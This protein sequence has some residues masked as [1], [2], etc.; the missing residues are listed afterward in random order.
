MDT[1]RSRVC[2]VLFH[3]L[4]FF[5]LRIMGD[6]SAQTEQ[7]C[8]H[9]RFDLLVK[10]TIAAHGGREVDFEEPGF[11]LVVN[12]DVKAEE[13][14]AVVFVRAKHFDCVVYDVLT[15]YDR[16]QNYVLY[17]FPNRFIIL[18]IELH[19]LSQGGN[20]PLRPLAVI[21]RIL[22]LLE[23]GIVLVQGVVR[24]MHILL[25]FQ[26]SFA[27]DI[28]LSGKSGQPIFID[29]DA[30][31]INAGERDID[32]QVEL[33]AVNKHRV[34]HVLGDD[35]LLSRRNVVDIFRDEDAFA[36]AR[37][38][39]LDDPGLRRIFD[40]L[41][42]QSSHLVWQDESQRQKLEVPVAVNFF[43]ACQ[44]PVHAVFAANLRTLR[45][46]IH[47]LVAAERLVKL[48]LDV[49]ASP[50]ELPL[51][52]AIVDLSEAIVFTGVPDQGHIDPVVEFEVIALI[53][54][55]VRPDRYGVNVG[56]KDQ[57][58]LVRL[59]TALNSLRGT[60]SF[61]KRH[62]KFA[63]LVLYL[64]LLNLTLDHVCLICSFDLGMSC[65]NARDGGLRL[66]WRESYVEQG[67]LLSSASSNFTSV[68]NILPAITVVPDGLL[69]VLFESIVPLDEL[70][71][72]P[73]H[74]F[75][76]LHH[77]LDVYLPHVACFVVRSGENGCVRS[78]HVRGARWIRITLGFVIHAL[79]RWVCRCLRLVIRVE[80]ADDIIQFVMVSSAAD[81]DV[82]V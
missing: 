75:E 78:Y 14:E 50:A 79:D 15:R 29:V 16:L 7:I 55:L 72:F 58:L 9:I 2:H 38:T 27:D 6:N 69:L 26:A 73:F 20:R 17:L 52:V 82:P 54:R 36:L 76:L 35:H 40:H 10:R 43:Q 66:P 74:L 42:L 57:M 24:Q 30:E 49:G 41:L 21:Q 5:L 23:V 53:S 70:L 39:R 3:L 47:F 60:Y 51:L 18:T 63:G 32:S 34:V 80:N 71:L 31:G 11:K 37:A 13:L 44:V 46:V 4:G 65:G 12:E 28:F 1:W 61:F 19:P 22:V 77:L 68:P 56:S 81:I 67:R 45:K 64:E 62:V 25:S 48:T 8:N 33:V 59:G